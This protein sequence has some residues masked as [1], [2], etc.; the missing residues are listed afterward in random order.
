[1][2]TIT[3]G[4]TRPFVATL[5]IGKT[6]VPISITDTVLMEIVDPK[7]QTK[8]TNSWAS[9]STDPG[10]DW[11]NGVVTVF[12]PD[13]ESIKLD[14]YAGKAILLV[15]QVQSLTLGKKEWQ[16]QYTVQKGYIP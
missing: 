13:I 7:T 11:V 10:A 6:I 9:I 8:I 5:K 14:A 3:A 4:D 1:M 15:V 2:A 12:I 16:S